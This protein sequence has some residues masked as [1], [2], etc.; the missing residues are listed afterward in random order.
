MIDEWQ[1]TFSTRLQIDR[2]NKKMVHKMRFKCALMLNGHVSCTIRDFDNINLKRGKI[3]VCNPTISCA[4]F[5][6]WK[7][8]F[9]RK[10][11]KQKRTEAAHRPVKF[12]RS[13]LGMTSQDK[14]LD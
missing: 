12:L 11:K 8:N 5:A 7:L 1:T 4:K 3:H 2:S 13:L 6:C 9:S 10:R 14:I